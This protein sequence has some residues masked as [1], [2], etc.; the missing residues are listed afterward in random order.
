MHKLI[1]YNSIKNGGL[2]NP[3][4]N[5]REAKGVSNDSLKM[6]I[7]SVSAHLASTKHEN[8]LFPFQCKALFLDLVK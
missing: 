6:L 2:I 8:P 7:A 5:R 4:F 1:G 3:P